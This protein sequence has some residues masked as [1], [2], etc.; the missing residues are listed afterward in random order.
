MGGRNY[1]FFNVEELE[2]LMRSA[3]FA[4]ACPPPTPALAPTHSSRGNVLGHGGCST[5]VGR[6]G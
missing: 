6:E 5:R 1:R 2:W 4:Q 3:G